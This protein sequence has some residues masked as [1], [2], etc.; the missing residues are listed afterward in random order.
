MNNSFRNREKCRETGSSSSSLSATTMEDVRQDEDDDRQDDCEDVEGDT[1]D[2]KLERVIGLLDGIMIN[3]GIV[4]GTG[5]FISPKGVLAGVNSVGA[6]LSVWVASGLISFLG[7]MCFA[8]VGTMIRTS[9]GPYMYIHRIFGDFMGFICF[10]ANVVIII[11]SS[12]AVVSLTF[13]FYSLQ[14]FYPDPSC[15]PPAS[16]IKLVA[17]LC[18][19]VVAFINCWSV[20][21]TSLLQDGATI[22]KLLALGV[23]IVSGFVKLGMGNVEN[24]QRPFESTDLGGLAMALYSCLFAYDGWQC[25]TMVVEELKNPTRNL[26]IAIIVSVVIVTSVYTFINVAYFAVLSPT[27]ILS[28]NAIAFS[29]GDLVLGNFWWIIT[30]AIVISTFGSLNGG[31][32]ASSRVIFAGAR[33]GHFPRLFAMVSI[34]HKTPSPSLVLVAATSIIFCFVD[35]VFILINYFNFA[36][37]MFFGLVGIGLIYL[38]FKAPDHPRPYKVNIVIPIVFV[39]I[40]ISLLVIGIVSAPKDAAIGAALMLSAIPV[41]FLLVRPKIH[42]TS[43]TN[44]IKKY[45]VIFCQKIMLVV[46]EEAAET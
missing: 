16:A 23:I 27:E 2:V 38:R 45:F 8:E 1:D 7:A 3:V 42:V 32:M 4:I 13:S 11:P 29:Y 34:R 17:V 33:E 24:F 15:P 6:A 9:G 22:F 30:L 10:W 41:Y 21:L 28:S 36:S 39:T 25:L 14:P 37:W 44:K 20:R 26:P 35:N 5:I 18:L 46:Q 19:L 12:S 40:C 31:Y 43:F